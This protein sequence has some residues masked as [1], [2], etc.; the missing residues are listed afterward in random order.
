MRLVP[1][2]V[3]HRLISAVPPPSFD[4]QGDNPVLR[5]RARFCSTMDFDWIDCHFD[6]KTITPLEVE[7]VFE[8]PF[9]IKL[10]PETENSAAEARYFTLGKTINNRHLFS[11][12]W[13]DGKRYRV[14]LCREMTEDEITFYERKNAEWL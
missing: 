8:D 12:F 4:S 3:F 14:I 1:N 7:E 10:L 13:T 11:I 2:T 9:S 5:N 6:L